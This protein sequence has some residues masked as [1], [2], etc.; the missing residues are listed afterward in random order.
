MLSIWF[1]LISRNVF[2]IFIR[3]L[4]KYDLKPLEQHIARED[5]K[6]PGSKN[7]EI[8]CDNKRVLACGIKAH[9]S[10]VFI[11]EHGAVICNEF[12]KDMQNIT[13]FLFVCFYN[14]NWVG[15]IK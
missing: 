5:T 6:T 14:I 15:I 13:F 3:T 7:I 12:S 1:N 9:S 8:W 11:H 2:L 4:C 10:L